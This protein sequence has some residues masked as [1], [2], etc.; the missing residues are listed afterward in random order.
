MSTHDY[1]YPRPWIVD[2][3]REGY[4]GLITVFDANGQAVVCTG[5]MESAGWADIQHGYLFAAAPELLDL[6]V[7]AQED[8]CLLN[9]GEAT[10]SNVCT[11]IRAAIAKAHGNTPPVDSPNGP[12]G[13]EGA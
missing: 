10:H 11:A 13:T 1:D 8:V 6:L 7:Q 5:D 4:E 2:D 9:C 3:N 12:Q